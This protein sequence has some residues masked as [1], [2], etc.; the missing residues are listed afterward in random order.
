MFCHSQSSCMQVKFVCCDLARDTPGIRTNSK[1]LKILIQP[2]KFTCIKFCIIGCLARGKQIVDGSSAG[3]Q[4][5]HFAAE[6]FV[7]R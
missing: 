1:Y 6:R 7:Q 3:T 2:H 4:Y 5:Y